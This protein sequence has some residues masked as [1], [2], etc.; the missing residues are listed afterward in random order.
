MIFAVLIKTYIKEGRGTYYKPS[1]ILCWTCL[2]GA[3][4]VGES[5]DPSDDGVDKNATVGQRYS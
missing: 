1:R 2:S 5:R 3:D 4:T